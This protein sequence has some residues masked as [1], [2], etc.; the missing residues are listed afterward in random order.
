[1]VIGNIT[2][3]IARNPLLRQFLIRAAT[4]IVRSQAEKAYDAYKKAAQEKNAKKRKMELDAIRGQAAQMNAEERIKLLELIKQEP[5]GPIRD[6]A[7]DTLITM[8]EE[9]KA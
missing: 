3:V 4:H 7:V 1:M 8:I 2:R 9:D 6:N 5:S